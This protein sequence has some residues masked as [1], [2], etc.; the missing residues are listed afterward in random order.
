MAIG[1]ATAWLFYIRNPEI[2]RALARTHRPL[3]LLLLNKWYF[4]ELYEYVF[5][6]PAKW[7][8]RFLWRKGDLGAIDG[9]LHSIAIGAVPFLTRM[10]GRLQSGYLY[11]YAFVMVVGMALIIAAIS[12][13]GGG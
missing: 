12:I 1:L 4:D 5:V 10:A 8:G 7:I 9:T 2:P 13:A 6:K 11:H 3:Y